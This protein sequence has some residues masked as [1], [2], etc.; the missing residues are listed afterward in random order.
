MPFPQ[1]LTRTA[2]AATAAAVALPAT[3]SASTAPA[4]LPVCQ[5]QSTF[6]AFTSFGDNRD[7][8]LAPGGDFE[9]GAAGWTLFNAA[10]V[11]G[12]EDLGILPGKFSLKLGVTNGSVVATTPEFCITQDHPTFR[13]LTKALTSNAY[14]TGLLTTITYRTAA[15]P[16]NSRTET[17][18][19]GLAP[20]TK[21]TASS[22]SPLATAIPA[23]QFKYGVAVKLSFM[24]NGGTSSA[25]GLLIDDVL[26]DPYRRS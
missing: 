12:N 18:T 26:V 8:S 25:G 7:Y 20:S 11:L 13:F 15:D 23:S 1:L 21:W 3:A 16:R 10:P 14:K 6:K 22:I 24:V 9:T 5:A 17:S 2:L 19:V 4:P